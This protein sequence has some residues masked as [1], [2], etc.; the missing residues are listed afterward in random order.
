MIGAEISRFC[1][2]YQSRVTHQVADAAMQVCRG[3]VDIL[4]VLDADEIRDLG[5]V[6]QAPIP[7]E[8]SPASG[9]SVQQIIEIGP[10]G[11]DLQSLVDVFLYPGHAV[12]PVC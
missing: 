10:T 9:A 12:R 7:S 6:I 1:V 3:M 8:Y 11:D 2:T 5:R 4:P